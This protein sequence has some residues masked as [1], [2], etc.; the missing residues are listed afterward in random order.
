MIIDD[1]LDPLLVNS[2]G[3]MPD[4]RIAVNRS[5]SCR[6]VAFL[7]ASRILSKSA[8]EEAATK[9]GNKLIILSMR[10]QAKWIKAMYPWPGFQLQLQPNLEHLSEFYG[11][12]PSAS[13][14]LV[15]S[16]TVQLPLCD[17]LVWSYGSPADAD[18]GIWF[19]LK[20]FLVIL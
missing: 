15:C 16:W 12:F 4:C 1:L 8:G 2:S 14:C 13:P 9:F 20:S 11:R 6:D 5:T 19:T 3:M 10:N 7:M 17:A 18:A